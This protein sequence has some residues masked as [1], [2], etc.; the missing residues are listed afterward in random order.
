[1]G[2]I[3]YEVVSREIMIWIYEKNKIKPQIYNI[4]TETSEK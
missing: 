4:N 3:I 1:M 2:N